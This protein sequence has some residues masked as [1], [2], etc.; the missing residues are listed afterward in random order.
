MRLVGEANDYVGKGMNGGE[1]IIRPPNESRF[2][3]ANNSIIGNT[4]LYGATGGKLF[5]AGRAGE[6]FCV[7]NSGGTAV[8]EGVGDHGCEYMTGGVA[9]VLGRTGLTLAPEW[10]G[11][12]PYVYDVNDGFSKLYND[13]MVSIERMD[14]NEEIKFLQGLIYEHLE[15]TESPRAN[16]ILQNWNDAFSQNLENRAASHGRTTLVQAGSRVGQTK[17]QNRRR[18]EGSRVLQAF[19][20]RSREMPKEARSSKLESR[21]P[22]ETRMSKSEWQTGKITDLDFSDASSNQSAD[23]LRPRQRAQRDS[24][25]KAERDVRL[26]TPTPGFDIRHSSFVIRH[27]L[28]SRPSRFSVNNP[29][30]PL[31][32]EIN[33]RCWL[34]DLRDRYAWP[35]SLGSVPEDEFRY[36]QRLGFTHIWLMVSL[37]NRP[38]LPR[39][40][41]TESQPEAGLQRGTAWLAN[42]RTF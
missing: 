27:F 22:K 7:R 1:I 24:H 26:P 17:N 37:G 15:K 30:H 31:V 32:Y 4:V 35:V 16:E 40:R 12:S 42:P 11:V 5:A 38:S 28:G 13:A 2:V 14:S 36:W 39:T 3:W 25:T 6:R 41:L 8:V 29:K 19:Q 9:V 33:T 23:V 34:T 10:A 21:I 18:E 20:G